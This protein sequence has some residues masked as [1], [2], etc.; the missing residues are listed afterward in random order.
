LLRHPLVLCVPVQAALLLSDLG[1]L[2][3]WGDEQ[4]SLDRAA[5]PFQHLVGTLQ[6]NVHPALYFLTLRA[7][8]SYVCRG[9][10]IVCARA[11]SAVILI[12]ATIVLDRLWLSRLDLRTRA[13]FL[14]LWTVSPVLLLY[15]RMARSYS[16]QL[17]LAIV[18]LEA[19]RRYVARYSVARL[20]AYVAAALALLYIHYLP[21]IAVVAAVAMV[22][23]WQQIRRRDRWGVFA[24]LV[25]LPIIALGLAGWLPMFLAALGRVGARAPY[26]VL[27]GTW[28][29]AAA[30][31]AYT[32]IAFTVGECVHGWMLAALAVLAVPIGVLL[33][34][35][36]RQRPPWL[37]IVAPAAVIAFV[38]ANHWVSYAFVAARVLWVLP[39]FLLLLVAGGDMMPRLRAAVCTGLVVLSLA[40]LHAYFGLSGFLNK[41][42][43]IPAAQI[44]RMIRDSPDSTSALVIADHHSCNLT[45]ATRALRSQTMLLFDQR[46]F[47]AAVRK[48][49]GH[50]GPVWFVRGTHDISPQGWNRRMEQALAS[51]FDIHRT[52]FTP[53]SALDRWLMGV[54]GWPERPT[55]VVEVL[56]MRRLRPD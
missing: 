1:R 46:S 19:G 33:M 32:F 11:F 37:P 44:D 30:V 42:Y 43:V 53:Y 29:D 23:L 27:G 26:R 21:A 7:W 54:A 56:E 39:F 18:A 47:D 55:H 15:G 25:P 4:A 8:L 40:G 12:V 3:L 20:A 41:A 22:M 17:L 38:G 13:W 48:A 5:M 28:L 50:R 9:D 35:G 10:S 36:L 52:P 49:H 51:D 45:A 16:L 31:L 34:Q 6:Y 2:P 14:V 24:A